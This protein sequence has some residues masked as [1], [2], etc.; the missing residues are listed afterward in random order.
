MAINRTPVAIEGPLVPIT[1][2]G[3]VQQGVDIRKGA[4]ANRPHVARRR[5][6]VG[7]VISPLPFL[8]RRCSRAIVEPEVEHLGSGLVDRARVYCVGYVRLAHAMTRNRT[9]RIDDVVVYPQ[10]QR[11][12]LSLRDT[13]GRE[14]TIRCCRACGPRNAQHHL[15]ALSALSRPDRN[16]FRKDETS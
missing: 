12:C 4:G 2:S 6:G 13:Q 3:I 9:D 10:E 16:L 15:Q 8:R 7:A 5:E 14:R 1:P 11:L